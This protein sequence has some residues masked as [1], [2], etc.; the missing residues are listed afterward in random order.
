MS[1]REKI[2]V[3]LAPEPQ[4]P[5]LVVNVD[6]LSPELAT[7]VFH[8]FLHLRRVREKFERRSVGDYNLPFYIVKARDLAFVRAFPD[9]LCWQPAGDMWMSSEVSFGCVVDHESQEYKDFE[10][11]YTYVSPQR[12]AYGIYPKIFL[13]EDGL[14]WNLPTKD[15]GIQQDDRRS[16]SL[17][18]K[19]VLWVLSESDLIADTPELLHALFLERLEKVYHTWERK[20]FN[21]LRK[22]EDKTVLS[23]SEALY[24]NAHRKSRSWSHPSGGNPD[25]CVQR[26][27]KGFYG[28][29]FRSK[30]DGRCHGEIL[31]IL[32]CME[33]DEEDCWPKSNSFKTLFGVF[34][35]KEISLMAAQIDAS[36]P[37]ARSL[38]SLVEGDGAVR[39]VNAV[40]DGKI[41]FV[42][43]KNF[44]HLLGQIADNRTH[45]RGFTQ[46]EVLQDLGLPNDTALAKIVCVGRSPSPTQ[47]HPPSSEDVVPES[48]NNIE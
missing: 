37:L 43:S 46:K 20:D 39:L 5:G 48:A 21:L 38:L 44:T 3:L 17:A 7:R 11:G 28:R 18:S 19:A 12:Y 8:V 47:E 16:S 1:H 36:N 26:L 24:Y 2:K 40:S 25:V 34:A 4:P 27:K 22:L 10:A 15:R 45:A 31:E 9:S 6:S 33:Y 32:Q 13:V 29:W 41:P 14:Q 23:P 35:Q 42:L 30:E